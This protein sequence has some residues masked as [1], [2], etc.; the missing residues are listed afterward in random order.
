M[1]VQKQE[2]RQVR[3]RLGLGK[4]CGQAATSEGVPCPLSPL[5]SGVVVGGSLWAGEQDLVLAGLQVT[6][7]V[8]SVP[9]QL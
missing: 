9:S 3:S 6:G 8:C 1:F 7:G 4:G 5:P 2:R